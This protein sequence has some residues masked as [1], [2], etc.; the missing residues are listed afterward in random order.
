MTSPGGILYLGEFK[1]DKQSGYGLLKNDEL[2]IGLF[3]DNN[4]IGFGLSS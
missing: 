3:K 2:K 1:N 4:L